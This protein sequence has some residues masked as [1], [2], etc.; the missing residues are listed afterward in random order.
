MDSAKGLCFELNKPLIAINALPVMAHSA[1]QNEADTGYLLCPLLD[2]RRM[3]VFFALY[4]NELNVIVPPQAIE[5][6]ID[7]VPV[8]CP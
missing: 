4:D 7:G 5:L 8:D 3:E 1:L 2:A 6:D